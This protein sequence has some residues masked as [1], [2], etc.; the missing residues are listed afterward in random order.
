M[1]KSIE[2]ERSET[3][4]LFFSY[5]QEDLIQ[6][7]GR[8]GLTPKM[9][10]ETPVTRTLYLGATVGMRPGV[11]IKVRSYSP[12]WAKNVYHITPDSEFDLLEIKLTT[13]QATISPS[14][15]DAQ[16]EGSD[17]IFSFQRNL[18][19]ALLKRRPRLKRKSRLMKTKNPSFPFGGKNG[20]KITFKQVIQVLAGSSELDEFLNPKLLNNLNGKVRPLYGKTILPYIVTQYGRI[21]FVPQED[22]GEWKD[23]V[24]VTI[25]PGCEFYNLVQKD[26]ETFVDKPEMIAEFLMKEKHSRLELKIDPTALE[27]Y[28]QF[29][30]DLKAIFKKYGV[31]NSIS[32][33]WTGL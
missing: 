12:D 31:M 1:S 17:L 2:F 32:K 7:F 19:D 24:R 14:L 10:M 22:A 13:G 11:S 30:N 29:K 5:D 15:L 9:Y 4:Y 28:P 8:I 20:N 3:L 18:D 21:H 27:Q 23:V 25:D 16:E 6:E 33:K 26:P